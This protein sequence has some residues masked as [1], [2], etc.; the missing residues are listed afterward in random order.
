MIER[1]RY[2]VAKYISDLQRME[3]RNIGIVVC[4]SGV[5]C[6]RFLGEKPGRPGHVDGRKVPPFVTSVAAY[7]Q[8]IEFW[9]GEFEDFPRRSSRAGWRS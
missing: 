3:P 2:L 4:A 7:K 9:R 8:W 1:P 5:T 6:A